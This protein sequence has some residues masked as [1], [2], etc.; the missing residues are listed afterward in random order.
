MGFITEETVNSRNERLLA[1]AQADVVAAARRA[2]EAELFCDPFNLDDVVGKV[3]SA[4]ERQYVQFGQVATVLV[5]APCVTEALHRD[6]GC[7][8]A[9]LETLRS[10]EPHTASAQLLYRL[11]DGH[12]VWPRVFVTFTPMLTGPTS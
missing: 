2:S 3:Q 10:Y 12:A 11:R 6:S 9:L 4:A 8:Q 7:E 1:G 5:S